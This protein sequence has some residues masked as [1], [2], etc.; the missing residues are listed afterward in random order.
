MEEF[1]LPSAYEALARAHTAAGNSVE[2]RRFVELGRA[3]TATLA[4]ADDRAQLE[5][6]FADIVP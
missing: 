1:D 5:T 4:D 6:Q 2:A 3:A